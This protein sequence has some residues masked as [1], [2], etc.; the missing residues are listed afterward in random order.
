MKPPISAS[1]LS[2]QK[3]PAHAFPH[4]NL[5]L[6]MELNLQWLI[7]VLE[8]ST[9]PAWQVKICEMH[10]RSV[11][12]SQSNG[13]FKKRNKAANANSF[14]VC[15]YTKYTTQTCSKTKSVKFS[16]GCSKSCQL[17]H[18]CCAWCQSVYLQQVLAFLSPLSTNGKARAQENL[19]PY[20]L[21]SQSTP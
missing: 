3:P 16:S 2:H 18:H 8:A 10:K 9:Q 1:L 7:N 5:I 15:S 11:K 13:R 6:H 17:F 12:I 4:Q 21:L 14:F 20:L 19:A